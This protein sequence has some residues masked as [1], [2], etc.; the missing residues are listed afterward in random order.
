MHEV[1]SRTGIDW[2]LISEH[3]VKSG[4]CTVYM[5]QEPVTFNSIA[6][7]SEPCRLLTFGNKV[8]L[9]SIK[10]NSVGDK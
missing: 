10:F 6:A 1:E 2:L 9:L 8:K 4:A 5:S 7:C 3:I